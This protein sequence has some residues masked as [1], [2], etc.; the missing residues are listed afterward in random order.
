MKKHLTK[1]YQGVQVSHSFMDENGSVFDCV[2]IE[3]Q[4]GLKGSLFKAPDL[5]GTEGEGGS[6]ENSIPSQVESQLSPKRKDRFGNAMS[7]ST[8]TVPVRR[9][10]LDELTRFERLQQFFQKSPTGSGRPPN[11]TVPTDAV[12]KP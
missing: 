3:Q 7:C 12:H 9:I 11:V 10:T 8:G 1:L 6:N 4:P 5:P 2:P